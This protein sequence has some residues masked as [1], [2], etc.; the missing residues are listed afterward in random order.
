MN[1]EIV[2]LLLR[3]VGAAVLL[4]FLGLIGWYLYQDVRLASAALAVQSQPLGHL[5]VVENPAGT[6]A[7]GTRY[8]LLP[9]TSIGRSSS[10]VIVLDDG[11]TSGQHSLITRRGDLWWL[12]DLGSRNGTLL[13]EVLLAETA[14]LSAGDIITI[15][16]IKLK[17]ELA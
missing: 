17:L 2:L 11:Y 3:L 7:V 1:P 9:V 15:G 16:N 12:E 13:N 4:A 14:V 10:N 6:P 5:T 8:P